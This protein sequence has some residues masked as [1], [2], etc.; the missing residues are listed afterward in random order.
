MLGCPVATLSIL[1]MQGCPFLLCNFFQKGL[2]KNRLGIIS[3]IMVRIECDGAGLAMIFE[4]SANG[5]PS[6][7][8]WNRYHEYVNLGAARK[9]G[10]NYLISDDEAGT[11]RI[12]VRFDAEADDRGVAS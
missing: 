7:A 1:D 2:A 8:A 9:S 11:I 10:Y 6:D 5:S 12:K 4:V 3:A